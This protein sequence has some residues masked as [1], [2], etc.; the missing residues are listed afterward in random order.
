[1]VAKTNRALRVRGVLAIAGALALANCSPPPGGDAGDGGDASVD[2]RTDTP[3]DVIRPDVQEPDVEQPDV[4]E[5]D[6]EQ[7]DVVVPPDEPPPP[8]DVVMPPDEPPPPVDVVMP[9]DDVVVPP[10]EPMPPMDVVVPDDVPMPPMDGGGGGDAS[11]MDAAVQ[12]DMGTPPD[13]VV[14]P[15]DMG[16]PDMGTPTEGGT[17]PT[18][19]TRM[20]VACGTSCSSPLDAVPSSDGATIYFTGFTPTGEAAVFRVAAAGGAIST[21]ASGNGL[22]LPV[23]VALSND[24]MTL[25]VADSAAVRNGSDANGAV[26]RLAVAGGMPSVFDTGVELTRAT[27]LAVAS[28]GASLLV[29]ATRIFDGVGAVFRLPI[30][31][32]TSSTLAADLV[33]PAGLSQG[34][35]GAVVVFDLQ[36]NNPR[37]GQAMTIATGSMRSAPLMASAT[38][39]AGF[40]AGLSHTVDGS[41]VLI[42][43]SVA[44]QTSLLTFVSG[45]TA[46]SPVAA[47]SGMAQ[48]L[49]LHR[50]RLSN[51]W[52]VADESA[53]GNGAIFVVTAR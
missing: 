6:V 37:L 26:F 46:T 24:D 28:D 32:G 21:V 1:M 13:D 23:S 2:V 40:P 47:S 15:P 52:A 19:T 39:Q 51:T 49:G 11:D 29:S 50:A 35:G 3:G 9:P 18:F 34:A 4:Q 36:N 12:P 25:F 5:P 53:M 31:G 10:D 20:V 44:G 42:S 33:Y 16:T 27:S 30:A 43:G 38:M 41:G 8:V 48:P 22:A 17:G 7:P 14:V 45:S